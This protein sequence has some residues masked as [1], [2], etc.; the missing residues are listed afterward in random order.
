VVFNTCTTAADHQQYRNH[1]TPHFLIDLI[2]LARK[3]S[4]I[5][6]IKS[7]IWHHTDTYKK[8]LRRL[9][10]YGALKTTFRVESERRDGDCYI[11]EIVHF[12]ILNIKHIYWSTLIRCGGDNQC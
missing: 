12:I 4:E 2:E 1:K 8:Y 5:Y 7:A 9:N 11:E 3:I 10:P 6:K